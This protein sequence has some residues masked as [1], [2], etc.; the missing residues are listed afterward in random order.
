MLAEYSMPYNPDALSTVWPFYVLAAL[1]YCAPII[2]AF[3]RNVE[4]KWG[5]YCATLLFGITGIGWAYC[6]YYAIFGDKEKPVP[7][8]TIAA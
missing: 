6:L 2:V 5:L 4:Y 8:L 1:V 7:K 3:F